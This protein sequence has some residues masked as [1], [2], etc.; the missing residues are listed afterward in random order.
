MTAQEKIGNTS[1]SKPLSLT[2]EEKTF[3]PPLTPATSP[4]GFTPPVPTSV[5]SQ[6][7]DPSNATCQHSLG[8]LLERHVEPAPEFED[9]QSRQTLMAEFAPL[10]RLHESEQYFP[11][12][13]SEYVTSCSLVDISN[14]NR[15][16]VPRFSAM[17]SSPLF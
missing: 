4:Y 1:A 8:S 9:E 11:A 7:T 5:Q 6:V 10:V 16:L 13:A 15:V 2:S 12:D 17:Y 14:G 3:N